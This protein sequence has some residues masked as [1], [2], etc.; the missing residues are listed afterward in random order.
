MSV[1]SVGHAGHDMLSVR[2]TICAPDRVGSPN[3]N[4]TVNWWIKSGGANLYYHG[5]LLATG[6]IGVPYATN[7][8]PQANILAPELLPGT[9]CGV[10]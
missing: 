1:P 8:S 9:P 7:L 10:P 6:P 2:E 5:Y 4:F 3:V